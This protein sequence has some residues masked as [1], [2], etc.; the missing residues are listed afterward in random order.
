MNAF[1]FIKTLAMIEA[2]LPGNIFNPWVPNIRR[3]DLL[4]ARD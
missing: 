4:K 3:A 1:C 2:V